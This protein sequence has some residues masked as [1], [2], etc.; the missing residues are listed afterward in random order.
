MGAS[1]ALRWELSFCDASEFG[2]RVHRAFTAGGEGDF[3]NESTGGVQQERDGDV[4]VMCASS[5]GKTVVFGIRSR[6]FRTR[7]VTLGFFISV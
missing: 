7:K 5:V 1:G 3:V 4:D 6:S 2:T